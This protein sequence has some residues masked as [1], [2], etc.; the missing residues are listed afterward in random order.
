MLYGTDAGYLPLVCFSIRSI[1]EHGSCPDVYIL[2]D[3]ELDDENRRKAEGYLKELGVSARLVAVPRER[4][5]DVHVD[6][7]IPWASY[8]RL[9]FDAYIPD[10]Y[11]RVLYLDADTRVRVDL[12]PL[13]STD[14]M[15]RVVG[16]VHDIYMLA[17]GPIATIRENLGLDPESSYFNAGVLLIDRAAWRERNVASRTL[18]FAFE[19]SDRC[20]FHD[21]CALNRTL[22]DDWQP[23]DFRWNYYTPVRE[24]I[25][26]CPPLFPNRVEGFIYHNVLGRVWQET[27]FVSSVPQNLWYAAAAA[28]SPWPDF[29]KRVTTCRRMEL[30]TRWFSRWIHYR[31]DAGLH[32]F[33]PQWVSRRRRR[34]L[35]DQSALSEFLQTNDPDVVMQHFHNNA[36]RR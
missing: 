30:W 6:H 29:V 18:A 19:A 23:L 16:A 1:V 9:F 25:S 36:L 13:W 31:L 15:G 21:Q 26:R 24:A 3:G 8:L 7:R 5:M 2:T 4:R 32:A 35:G 11:E 27:P 22:R 28:D 12:T 10:T 33:S 17:K 14:L 20:R 34:E